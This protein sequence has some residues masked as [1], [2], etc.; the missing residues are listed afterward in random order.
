MVIN[1]NDLSTSYTDL[2]GK[3]PCKSSSSS[4]YILIAY[5]FD[6][7]CIIDR[8]LKNRNAEKITKSWQT[9]HN[10][11]TQADVAPNTYV[12]DNEISSDFIAALTKNN[13]SYQ[14]VLPHTHRRNLGELAIQNFKNQFQVRSSKR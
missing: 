13:T 12:R 9:I 1:W 3:F 11:F 7:N 14:L 10:I 6:G 2:T 8:A 5:H 4:D